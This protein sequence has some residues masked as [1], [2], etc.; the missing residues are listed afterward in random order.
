MTGKHV[1]P[2]ITESFSCPHCGAFAHQT[3]FQSYVLNYQTGSLP[4]QEI[5]EDYADLVE[6]EINWND[7]TKKLMSSF[8]ERIFNGL[9]FTDEKDENIYGRRIFN[10]DLARCYSCK[11]FSIWTSGK[12]IYPDFE[13]VLSPNQDM[14]EEVQKDFLESAVILKY[15][16]RG[17]AALLRL[18]V[19]KLCKFLG[20]KGKNIN[21]DIGSLVKKG[22][23][24]RIQKALDVVRVIGNEAV[25]PGQIDLNDNTETANKLFQL[26]NMISE[27][28][29]S[30][31][32]AVNELYQSLPEEKRNDIVKRDA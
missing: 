19:Q 12:I 22:L 29:I 15:S 21:D 7:D 17:S 18:C 1:T 10:L 9:I 8:Y 20:E 5:R 31:P 28:M 4:V 25:H 2:E 3:W 13:N 23:D 30:Q 26:V 6:A 11:K 27:A 14:P 16:P 24:V 32:K